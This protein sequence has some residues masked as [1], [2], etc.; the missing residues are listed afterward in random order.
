MPFG[1][2]FYADIL[3][4]AGKARVGEPAL[5]ALSDLALILS[6]RDEI[7]NLLQEGAPWIERLGLSD[8]IF[9]VAGDA[10]SAARAAAELFYHL[11][12]LNASRPQSAVLLRGGIATGEYKIVPSIF[13]ESA[14]KNLVGAGVVAAVRL[15]SSGAKGPRLLLDEPTAALI[16]HSGLA[17]AFR[18][19]EVAEML[20]PIIDTADGIDLASLRPVF[21]GAC[22]VILEGLRTAEAD[23]FI[24]YTE[25]IARCFERLGERDAAA[26]GALASAC[27]LKDLTENLTQIVE[28]QLTPADRALRLLRS[29]AGV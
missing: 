24:A 16:E 27:P 20:W 10:V 26:A 8:S 28:R 5:D 23:Q 29:W 2:I 1:I 22:E 17:Y 4:F 15:E 9:L 13:S 14:G 25:L 21:R 7:S 19:G 3:G 18:R 12:Y 6:D 11:A